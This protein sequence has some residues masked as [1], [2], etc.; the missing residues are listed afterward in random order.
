MVANDLK[1]LTG[2]LN[3]LTLRTLEGAA[4]LCLSKTHFNVEI[5]HWILKLLETQ[6]TDLELILNQYEIDKGRLA[7]DL[8]ASLNMLKTGNGR[9]PQLSPDISE[10]IRQAWL[11]ASVDFN[12]SR[13]RSGHLLA[14][15]LSD[16]D[17][18]SR[19]KSSSSELGKIKT[20]KL[21]AEL[22]ML[23]QESKE[24]PGVMASGNEGSASA[25][26]PGKVNPNSKTPNL[27][28]F[29]QNLTEIA[30]QGKIDPVLGRDPEIRQVID[31]L[32][33]RRQNNPI[34]AG[35]AGVGKTA[36]V[37]GFALRI[38]KGDVPDKL[39]NVSLRSLD[40][41]L[42]QAGAGVKGEFE[43][44]LK[45]VI[46][47]VQA[48][49]TPII[50]FIDEAHTL[51][52]AGGQAGSGDAA[53]LLKPAL[54]RGELRTVAATTF[55]EYKK[56]FEDD[57]A[58]KRR[59]QLIRV[60]EP[61][62]AKAV[63]MVRGIAASL[64]KH[65]GVSILDEAIEES[66]RLSQR[67]IPDRQ[68]P[69]K[70]I[71][72][73]DT[74]CA[75][76]ALSQSTIPPAIEDSTR[77]IDRLNTTISIWEKETQLGTTHSEELTD[78]K[79]Q[80]EKEKA[81]K[82]L[83]EENWGKE[84]EFVTKIRD[85]R[86]KLS[87]SI[88]DKAENP[89]SETD[90]QSLRAELVSQNES[91]SNLQGEKP[92]VHP[93]VNGSVVA[94]IV[95]GWTGIP[96]GKMVRNEI[97]SL[98]SLGNTLKSRVVGQDHAMDILAERI[99]TSRAKLTDPRLPVGVFM[100]VG[101]S[102]VGKT[103]TA[104]TLADMMFGG[105]SSMTVINMS[106]Y[107]SEMMTSRLTGPAPGLVGYGKGG[108]LTEAVRRRPN[109]LLLLD[110]IEKSHP[111]VHDLFFQVFDKGSLTDEKGLETD[112][113]NTIILMTSNAGTDKILKL[114]ADPETI[115]SVKALGEQLRPELLK[116]FKDAFLGRITVVPYFPLSQEV[117]RKIVN[118]KLDRVGDRVR[119]GYKAH[120]N[121]DKSLVDAILARCNEAESGAR[122]VDKII[123]T[124]LLPDISRK[125]LG[126]IA[127][128]KKIKEVNLK[129]SSTELYDIEIC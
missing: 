85:L 94:E 32:T 93:V 84:Q 9:A 4:G 74:S 51:I 45:S 102:G 105:E 7:R 16:R 53:N 13:I 124:T 1:A 62:R 39:K 71:S 30:R 41:G 61:D 92:L 56:S 44:R 100:L 37:E 60:E 68:L 47:E 42:L 20:D 52:G 99:Q 103:E 122:I 22:P 40:I 28:Q 88:N 95:S 46:S 87:T 5:E 98:L 89:L 112:F 73:L 90:R 19:V 66:V 64:E 106:E 109:T 8:N 23:F 101:P 17:L 21:I 33:R 69:D 38:V 43:N 2:K 36:V 116:S 63:D 18:A 79:G 70:A 76:V 58:L 91:L 35:E 77:E 3:P 111:S 34:L 119:E 14:A 115:P 117:L 110:E 126:M 12:A 10:L 83:L 15:A 31:I 54:A 78:L 104:I 55:D 6:D 86:K 114:C 26:G 129:A 67:Y 123:N 11:L 57:P 128:G 97:N 48:S 59:F 82:V 49:P 75:R 127:D 65:H 113:K 27:D 25:G 81:R 50:L 118:L 96:L 72:L 108:V 125:I 107:K 120:W 80:L 29:T 24:N 121:Y